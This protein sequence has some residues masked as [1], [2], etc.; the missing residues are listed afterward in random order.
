MIYTAAV[1]GCGRIGCGFDDEYQ[2]RKIIHTHAG[3]YK[4]NNNINLIALSDLDKEKLNK[5]SLKYKTN[6]YLNYKDL[7]ETETPDIVSICTRDHLRL[8]IIEEC[9]KYNV[10]AIFCEKPLS[11]SPEEAK[12]IISICEENN[13]LLT[14]NHIR[15]FG[16]F[17]K[18]F[19]QAISNNEIGDIQQITCYYS[20]GIFNSGTHFIDLLLMYF[21]EIEWVSGIRSTNQFNNQEI[22]ADATYYNQE[23]NIDGIL[24]FKNG[25]RAHLQAINSGYGVQE[26]NILSTKGRILVNLLAPFTTQ[27]FIRFEKPCENKFFEGYREL[28]SDV[29]FPINLNTTIKSNSYM[30]AAAEHIVDCLQKK[31]KYSCSGGYNALDGL[32]VICALL[33]SADNSGAREGV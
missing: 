28:F 20:G 2:R 4:N 24:H 13:I 19:S 14:V 25:Y 26:L 32:K 1:I 5:Y 10:K 23:I 30:P 15:R 12:K 33:R 22:N 9:A 11:R 18:D 31:I 3:S 6:K 17:H 8:E 16:G 7:L 27:P 21:G 29:S